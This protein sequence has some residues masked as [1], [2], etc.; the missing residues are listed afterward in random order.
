LDLA[1]FFGLRMVNTNTTRASEKP[2]QNK[3]RKEETRTAFDQVDAWRRLFSC[4]ELAGLLRPGHLRRDQSSISSSPRENRKS[5]GWFTV[6]VRI[7]T[8]DSVTFF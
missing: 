8:G 3:H 5:D 7:V 1:F 2:A 4:F 6:V